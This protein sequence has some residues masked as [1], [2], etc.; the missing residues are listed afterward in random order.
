MN[1]LPTLHPHNGV[2]GFRPAFFGDEIY[3]F[4]EQFIPREMKGLFK[5][6]VDI[7]GNAFDVVDDDWVGG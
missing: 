4:A 5:G 7:G 6:W 3:L 2:L 1:F